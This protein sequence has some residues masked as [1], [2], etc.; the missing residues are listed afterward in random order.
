MMHIK[1][2]YKDSLSEWKWREQECTVSSVAECKKL[3][4]LGIDCEYQIIS[5]EEVNDREDK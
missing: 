2:K 3:Y 5:V 4:G 1:F